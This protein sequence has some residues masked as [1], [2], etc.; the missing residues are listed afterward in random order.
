[1]LV[2]EK[3]TVNITGPFTVN[4]HIIMGCCLHFQDEFRVN[5]LYT[6][7]GHPERKPVNICSSCQLLLVPSSSDVARP[8][9]RKR[10]LRCS[11]SCPS[12]FLSNQS[13]RVS[14]LEPH[15]LLLPTPQLQILGC[16]AFHSLLS[17]LI[18]HS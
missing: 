3:E 1:M 6:H 11:I 7:A 5:L 16:P 14:K 17:E 8:F 4:L 12:R 10:I 18:Q 15:C 2:Q 13:C 9:T